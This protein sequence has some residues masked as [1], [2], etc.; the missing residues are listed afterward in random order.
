L[1]N[2][3]PLERNIVDA[4]L[5]KIARYAK[6]KTALKIKGWIVED[7]AIEIGALGFIAK[8]FDFALRRLGFG[9]TQRKYI[10]KVAGKLLPLNLNHILSP[11]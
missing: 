7:F 10:R 8:S 11:Q 6:L 9:K 4:Q 5:R 3:A 1:E 2:T